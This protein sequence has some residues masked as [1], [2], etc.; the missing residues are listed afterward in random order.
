MAG[1]K[2]STQE[3]KYC[4]RGIEEEHIIDENN[5][6][7]TD[8]DNANDSEIINQALVDISS[9]LNEVRDVAKRSKQEEFNT[10]FL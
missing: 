9:Q 4:I 8:F 6:F 5:L 3:E 7:P 10:K 2:Y 1:S